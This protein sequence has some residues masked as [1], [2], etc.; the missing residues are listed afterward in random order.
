MDIC[1]YIFYLISIILFLTIF[2]YFYKERKENYT[3]TIG[4]SYILKNDSF[5]YY[6]KERNNK[7]KD[8]AIVTTL[9]KYHINVIYSFVRS[10]DDVN[11]KGHII[12]FVSERFKLNF[13]NPIIHQLI[14][15]DKYPFYSSANKE[16]SIQK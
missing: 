11:F 9:I 8:I 10:L 12:L 5:K 6:N 15:L 1:K 13:S 16:F 2:S 7:E 14:V 3:P 4:M